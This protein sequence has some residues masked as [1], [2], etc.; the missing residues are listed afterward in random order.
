ERQ[1][2]TVTGG[3]PVETT[4]N[5]LP[6]AGID[7]SFRLDG[8][9]LL[10]SLLVTGIGALVSSYAV[11]YF[12]DA[13][14]GT[15]ARFLLLIHLFMTAML[16]TVLADNTIVMYLFWE[17]TSLISFMLIGFEAFRKEAREAALQSLLL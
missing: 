14:K 8:L 15:R 2:D 6:S 3:T 12:A 11:A 9:S 10:F 17:W 7:L 13:S 5:W 1:V 16:G 4:L